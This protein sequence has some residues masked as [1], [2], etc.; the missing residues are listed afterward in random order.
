MEITV[1]CRNRERADMVQS[2]VVFY[3]QELK[4]QRSRYN[5][6]VVL[7]SGMRRNDGIRGVLSL[8]PD[9]PDTLI[10]HVDS[11]L[12]FETLTATLAHEMIH[13]K[14]YARGQIKA[15]SRGS[16]VYHTWLGKRYRGN[17]YDSPWEQDAFRNERLLANKIARL[18]D[19]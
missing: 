17:Y 15:Q 13:V 9:Y 12:D 1:A 18:L 14:Q 16:R 10:M 4:I 2:I 19:A 7:K 6:H 11:R 3:A 8:S 5:V